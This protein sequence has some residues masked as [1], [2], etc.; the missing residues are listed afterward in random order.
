MVGFPREI[1]FPKAASKA[2]KGALQ[3]KPSPR[4]TPVQTP[5]PFS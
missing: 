2:K 4:Q 5:A 3:G 1:L